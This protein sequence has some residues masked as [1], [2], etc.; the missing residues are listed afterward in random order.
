MAT[1]LRVTWV[2][3]A[4]GHPMQQKKTIHALGLR[5]LNYTVE[6]PDNPGVRG[7]IFKVKHLVRVEEVSE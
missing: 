1:K 2:H 7:M 4:I 5:R 6:L 3:S